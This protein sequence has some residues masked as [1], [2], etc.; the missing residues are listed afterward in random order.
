[1]PRSMRATRAREQRVRCGNPGVIDDG[2]AREEPVAANR[3]SAGMPTQVVRSRRSW[4]PRSRA[5]ATTAR[6]D[7][8]DLASS[9][10]AAD[11]ALVVR[12]HVRAS[13]SRARARQRPSG[14][15]SRLP[16]AVSQTRGRLGPY[17]RRSRTRARLRDV[18]G[19]RSRARTDAGR[20]RAPLGTLAVEQVRG[21]GRARQRLTCRRSRGF[22]RSRPACSAC[23]PS[24]RRWPRG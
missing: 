20:G 16:S 17:G 22:R 6:G 10:A 12:A 21:R 23:R 4:R 15:R 7:A 18:R 9:R 24:P 2:E 14:G 3:H 11:G 1:M 5:S 19:W 8:R 13:L